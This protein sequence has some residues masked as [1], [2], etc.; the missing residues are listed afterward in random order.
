MT[1]RKKAWLLAG[2][3]LV[4]GGL[5]AIRVSTS[6]EPPRAP[7]TYRS[8]QALV[9]ADTHPAAG[10][11]AVVKATASPESAL[12][13]HPPKNI[14]APL[15]RRIELAMAPRSESDGQAMRPGGGKARKG[16]Q[17]G[18]S[19]MDIV[20]AQARTQQDQEAVQARQRMAQYRFI[21][22][23]SQNGEPRAFLGKGT[24]LYIVRAGETLEDQ[25]RVASI[26]T[27]SLRLRDAVSHTESALP[28]TPVPSTPGLH[29]TDE[30][31][32]AG[33]E[34]HAATQEHR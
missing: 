18:L 12:T 8:G 31:T 26:G 32:P 15:G 28:L 23:L 4:W 21:G 9:K 22:Y 20:I 33:I 30:P 16:T 11:T 29:P 2:L 17:P 25:I 3:I 1:A 5:L 14:F 19:P 10:I 6:P 27:T 34:E 13:L 7:L 24:D